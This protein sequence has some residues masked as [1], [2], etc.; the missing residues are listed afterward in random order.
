M[1]KFLYTVT[2]KNFL[3]KS[4]LFLFINT[5]SE[6]DYSLIVHS[7]IHS[8][9]IFIYFSKW[10]HTNSVILA[11]GSEDNS[12]EFYLKSETDSYYFSSATWNSITKEYPNNF[13]SAIRHNVG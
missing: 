8:F 5:R 9:R 7:F 13:A 6:A 2:S 1:C 3:L 4:L 12:V 11:I 10:L